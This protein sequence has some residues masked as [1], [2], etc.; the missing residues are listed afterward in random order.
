MNHSEHFS[1]SVAGY[2][3]CHPCHPYPPIHTTFSYQPNALGILCV[4]G[5]C[6]GAASTSFDP[7]CK[8]LVSESYPIP[9]QCS[10]NLLEVTFISFWEHT[11]QMVEPFT[12][13]YV[14]A[15]GV[16]RFLG[17]AHWIIQVSLDIFKFLQA[18]KFSF[19]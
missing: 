4:F 17:C 18:F 19:H 12:A 9:N 6:F 14:F 13:H 5:I 8:G 1:Q 2:S 11:F 3:F 15:L 7:E 16:A 10:I